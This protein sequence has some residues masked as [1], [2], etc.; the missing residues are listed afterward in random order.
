M[1][2]ALGWV[3]LAVAVAAVVVA[4]L[5]I[6][7]DTAP[8]SRLPQ[9][10]ESRQAAALLAEVADAPATP[11]ADLPEGEP[12]TALRAPRLPVARTIAEQGGLRLVGGAFNRARPG[13]DRFVRVEGARVG[14]ATLPLPPWYQTMQP[15][16]NQLAPLAA[17]D[18]DGDGWPDVAV[19][20]S[21][22]VFLYRNLGGRF[23]LER[24]IARRP[25]VSYVAL[26]DLNG[27]GRPD[28]F[29]CA[30]KAGC[31]IAANGRDGFGDEV[32]LPRGKETAVHSAAFG[33]VDRDGR[34]DIVTGPGSELEWNFTPR[35]NALVL[36][37][38]RGGGRFDLE[39]LP[40][41]RGETLTLLLHDLDDDGWPDLYAGNDFDEPSVVFAN[42]R[43]RL[44]PLDKEAAPLPRSTMSTMS[45]DAGDVDND[46]RAEIYDAGI[47]FG[48]ISASALEKRRTPP[49]LAC[50]G[51]YA[52]GP[53]LTRC[54]QLGEFQTAVVRSRDITDV[55]ECERFADATA[56][57]DCIGAGYLWNRTFA[58]LPKTASPE[59]VVEACRSL[60]AALATMRDLC[61]PARRSPIDFGQRHKAVIDQIPQVDETN[62]LL[63]P[64]GRGY[65]D[66][67][68]RFGVEH[69]GWS[70]N[71]KFA[72]LDNDT[73]QD[74]FIA[75]GTR[76]RFGAT[77]N[78]FYRNRQGARFTDEADRVGLRDHVPTGGSLALD[79]NLDGRLDLVT[80]PFALTPVVF[81][82]DLD[83]QP[84]LQIALRDRGSDNSE[85]IGA[86]VVIRGDDGRVQMREIKASGG[87]GSHD[88]TVARF[89]LGDWG[90]IRS[91]EVTWPDGKRQKL[92][93]LELR[94]GRYTLERR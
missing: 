72:D 26:V 57:R 63:A 18:V 58:D 32:R 31:S 44:V 24:S 79:V 52:D 70:W 76:L 81:G 67:A 71:A 20:T 59:V 39:A 11:A 64:A 82:N 60:P 27:D 9:D 42:R 13:K 75:Q 90:S 68:K 45:L 65:R 1:R 77:S 25:L 15:G 46:G 34:V 54:L 86:R 92:G 3:A 41:P 93:G 19:G 2:V 33:D 87:Y 8:A 56:R 66:V 43:G 89:G 17:G 16:V 69:G 37:R 49:H 78:L 84:G 10:D 48:G 91:L 73:W 61:E 29:S 7:S 30:W 12:R 47:G 80:A 38:N 55:G 50:R 83:V 88:W 6:S 94:A 36:W 51:V 23:G 74:L 14:F 35:D 5:V 28:L 85:A 40:G 22:G 62:L 4:R 53:E 21:H